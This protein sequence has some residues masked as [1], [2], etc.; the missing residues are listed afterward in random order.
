MNETHIEAHRL[1][2][3]KLPITLCPAGSKKPLGEGWTATYPGKV[4]QKKRW[5]LKEIDRAFKVY[6]E[7]NVGVL[8][9]PASGLIDIELDAPEDRAAFAELFDGCPPPVTATFS[10]QRGVHHLFAW[11]PNLEQI[12]KGVAHFHG[13][14]LRIGAGG[15]GAHSAFPPSS[16]NGVARRWLNPL[17]DCPAAAVPQLALERI[18]QASMTAAGVAVPVAES[19]LS[20]SAEDNRDTECTEI[21]SVSLLSL[22]LCNP[23]QHAI[24]QA[25]KL[26]K[27][28]SKG[29]RHRCLFRFA[30]HLKA[31]PSLANAEA[32]SLRPIVHQWFEAALPNI[33]TKEFDE[34]WADFCTA[35]ENVKFPAGQ[36]PIHQIYQ[37]AIAKP[38][39]PAVEQYESPSLRSLVALCNELQQLAGPEPFYLACRTAG[40]VLGINHVLAS[41]W[42]RQ[43]ERDNI[44][45]ITKRGTQNRASRY[46]YL[47]D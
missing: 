31:I 40:E 10:S 28:S 41:K 20:S 2:R 24:T 9:G 39:P 21:A 25:I 33:A 26:T 32:A 35:W 38:L 1:H 4:W 30:R 29:H 47:K 37:Q 18:I 11:H 46:R 27:P 8:F 36:E 45:E 7:L 42:L 13:L 6:G 12:G 23:Q 34:T 22:S 43:L 16:T 44:L 15:K 5:S 3:M 19:M 14:E 17:E